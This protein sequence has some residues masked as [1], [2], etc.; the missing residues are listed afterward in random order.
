VAAAIGGFAFKRKLT[1]R[2]TRWFDIG[3]RG[4]VNTDAYLA[5]SKGRVVLESEGRSPALEK[6]VCFFL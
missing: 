4:R 5:T 3:A 2:E 6:G 1:A